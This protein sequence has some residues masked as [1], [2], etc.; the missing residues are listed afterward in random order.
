MAL[1]FKMNSILNGFLVDR[2]FLLLCVTD[3][4]FPG[5]V[6]HKTHLD[7]NKMPFI[8]DWMVQSNT[9]TDTEMKLPFDLN[10]VSTNLI[11]FWDIN[12]LLQLINTEG[13]N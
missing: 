12:I 3:L 2:C 5:P 7:E 8:K 10:S 4:Q 1:H 6:L 13:K 11:K 9:Q